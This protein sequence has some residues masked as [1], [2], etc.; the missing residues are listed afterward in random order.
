MISTIKGWVMPALINFKESNS[1]YFKAFIVSV[2]IQFAALSFAAVQ[3]P[4]TYS[5]IPVVEN[6]FSSSS[7]W[8]GWLGLFGAIT[9]V[10]EYHVS[11][12]FAGVVCGYVAAILSFVVLVYDLLYHEPPI[13][14]GGIMSV[15]AV[16][17]LGA[18][19]YERVR[20]KV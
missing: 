13:Y 3:L 6:L 4:D 12:W 15:T 7:F 5:A 2:L 1:F 8:W 14:T 16:I 10:L 17:F 11:K 18:L 19:V 9:L 20:S